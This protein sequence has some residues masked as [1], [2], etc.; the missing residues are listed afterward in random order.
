MD[1]YEGTGRAARLPPAVFSTVM[2][3]GIVAIDAAAQGF[4]GGAGWLF[5]LSALMLAVLWVLF[6]VRL[7][8]HRGRVMQDLCDP[9]LA[10]GFFTVVAG[11][12]VV[13]SACVSLGGPASIAAALFAT[14]AVAW[15]VITYAVFTAQV[16]SFDPPQGHHGPDAAWLLAVVATQSLCVLGS[17]LAVHAPAPLRAALDFADVCA[18]ALGG[19]LYLVLM[20]LLLQ[21]AV[22]RRFEPRDLTPAWWI[23]MGAMAIS[24]LAGAQLVLEAEGSSAG[25]GMLPGLLPA[26]RVMTLLCWAV[27]TWWLPLL[28]LLNAWRARRERALAALASWSAVFPLGMYSVASG[29]VAAAFHLDFL[30]RVSTVFFWIALAAWIATALV[31]VRPACTYMSSRSSRRP[32]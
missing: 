3:T 22:F 31:S 11:T 21:R 29:R 28:V 24:T 18:W 19:V 10:P 4:S 7:A 23:A 15:F 2:A 32:A 12:A 14:A 1:L 17:L 6:A 16:T 8:R 25:D 13:G 26:L 5:A 27:A 9:V 30:Q 20:G